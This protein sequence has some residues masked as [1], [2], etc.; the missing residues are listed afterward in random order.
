[1]RLR[2]SLSSSTTSNASAANADR[3]RRRRRLAAAAL[4]SVVL[5]VLG[6]VLFI[7]GNREVDP[8][9]RVV[10]SDALGWVRIDPHASSDAVSL[11]ARFPALRDLPDR[12]AATFGLSASQLDL[13]RDVRPWLGDDAG[14]AWL[15][16]GSTLLLATV[17][18]RGKADAALRRLG[19]TASGP[20]LYELPAPGATA[21]IARDVLAAG[22]AAAVRAALARVETGGGMAGTAAYQHAMRSR[23]D[24]A[25]LEVYAPAAG[26]QRLV[27]SS[28]PLVRAAA[29]LLNGA[30]LDAVAAEIS[31]GDGG[32]T[33]QARLLRRSGTP[34]PAEFAPSLLG[35]VPRAGT[36]ALLDL[37]SASALEGIAARLGGAGVVAGA[38]SAVG[39][40]VSVDLER[41]VIAPLRGEAAL[42]VQA[43][44][45]VPVFTLAARTVSAPTTREA[46]AR[47]QA[48]LAGRLTG[49]TAGVFQTRE[50]GSFTLP[51]TARLQP[52]YGL[53]GNVLVATTAQPGLEQLRAAPRGIA[54]AP[55]LQQ[56]LARAEDRVQALGFF[57][58]H[59]LLEL[60]ERTGLVAGSGL[61]AARAALDPVEAVGAVV[62]QEPDHPTDTTAELFLQIP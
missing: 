11:A 26:V 38:Q 46:L 53:S 56:V 7:N 14:V 2:A 32:A 19:A 61:D 13:G 6:L 10:P 45:D 34:A 37:P 4:A 35:R 60:V 47:L 44:G 29:G 58:L 21:G 48:P 20:G 27:G 17:S 57:D 16:D 28:Q 9:A 49:G 40:P 30:S 8:L 50:D 51:V 23:G 18:D 39:D 24:R 3:F 12:L 1:M 33:V 5:I 36:A 25:P 62:A 42:S 52:S 41:D 59:A 22:P 31:P 15:S 55:A 54:Q 43:R